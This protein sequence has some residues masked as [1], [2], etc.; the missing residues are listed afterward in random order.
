MY[1]P[2][3]APHTERKR[4]QDRLLVPSKRIKATVPTPPTT[5]IST[6]PC[7]TEAVIAESEVIAVS[8]NDVVQVEDQSR[9][10]ATNIAY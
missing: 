3:S 8:S 7:T 5:T 1:H 6:S 2:E 10:R 4:L 9:I